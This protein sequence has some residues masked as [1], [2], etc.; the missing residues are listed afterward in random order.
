MVSSAKQTLDA[1]PVAACFWY[2]TCQPVALGQLG[3]RR[4]AFATTGTAGAGKAWDSSTET[5]Y[6]RT[7]SGAERKPAPGCSTPRWFLME[8]ED[9][10]CM[11]M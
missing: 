7:V 11:E 3:P 1:T 9:A 10:D 4:R 5:R 6:G 8:R 2:F